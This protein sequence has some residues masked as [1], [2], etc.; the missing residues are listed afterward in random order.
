MSI[1]PQ[2]MDLL[3]R[4]EELKQQGQSPSPEELCRDCPQ[5]IPEFQ[6]QFRLLV[7]FE[8]RVGSADD[9]MPIPPL[10]L[11]PATQDAQPA[12]TRAA[13]PSR[14]QRLYF[15]KRGGLGEVYRARDTELNRE[16]ALKN[17][18]NCRDESDR[19]RFLREAEITAR[20]EHPGVVPVYGLV[21]GD[22][23]ELCYAMRFIEGETLQEALERYHSTA[24]FGT[25]PGE[26]SVALHGLLGRFVAVCNTVAYA[27]SRGVLH[28]DL[29]PANVM[30]G[31]YGETLVVDWGLAKPF[32]REEA[33]RA[34]GEDTLRPTTES[35]DSGT[36]TGKALG[37][38]AYMS[39]EQAAG[40]WAE[41]GPASDVYSL[42][43]TLYAVLTGQAPFQ[44]RTW[45]EVLSGARWSI[46]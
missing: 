29:K 24:K 1:D 32:E 11:L 7:A 30:L 33:N 4:Y 21:P 13:L 36:L 9:A 15:H 5:L 27:H 20:L 35:T 16:V 41:V 6:R 25:D 10:P 22:D 28:R 38:P 45:Q 42:G 2:V 18:Q 12:A 26:R 43:A 44:G 19:R 34:A 46:R 37:T 3:L 23:G 39:P 31:K 8:R 40:R 17:M 14:Y